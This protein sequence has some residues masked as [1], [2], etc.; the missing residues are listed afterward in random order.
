LFVKLSTQYSGS[1]SLSRRWKDTTFD[2]DSFNVG[3]QETGPNNFTPGKASSAANFDIEDYGVIKF[4]MHYMLR[5]K[6]GRYLTAALDESKTPHAH[7]KLASSGVSSVLSK[8]YSLS[9]DGQGVGD[10]LDSLCFVNIDDK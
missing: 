8:V 6:L 7:A 9:V 5:G 10:P 1:S 3:S 4:S 2:E